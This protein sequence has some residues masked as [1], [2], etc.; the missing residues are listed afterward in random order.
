MG[1]SLHSKPSAEAACKTLIEQAVLL[2]RR[3]MDDYRDDITAIVVRLSPFDLLRQEWKSE[4]A[5]RTARGSYVMFGAHRR[6]QSCGDGAI[7]ADISEQDR[8]VV[9]MG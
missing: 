1:A 3:E 7:G 2:W 5:E 8:P 4:Q 6:H 9:V